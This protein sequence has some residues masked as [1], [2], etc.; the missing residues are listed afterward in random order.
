MNIIVSSHWSA[1]VIG[2]IAV[3]LHLLTSIDREVT[4]SQGSSF[5]LMPD[6]LRQKHRGAFH[7]GSEDSRLLLPP[8]A[9]PDPVLKPDS[10]HPSPSKRSNYNSK[11]HAWLGN[12]SKKVPFPCISKWKKAP[13]QFGAISCGRWWRSSESRFEG[14]EWQRKPQL[15]QTRC[16]WH[17]KIT[18]FT[19]QKSH[20]QQCF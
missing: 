18:P 12:I 19:F 8:G 10:F 20:C 17:D 16:R 5:H 11:R 3:H 6:S 15:R 2:D 7:P 4:T 13:C 9:V 14:A 1:K